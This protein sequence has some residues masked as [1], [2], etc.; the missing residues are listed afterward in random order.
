MSEKEI[1]IVDESPEAAKG[2]TQSDLESKTIKQLKEILH[3]LTLKV[4][5][6]KSELIERIINDKNNTLKRSLEDPENTGRSNKKQ[7]ISNDDPILKG[8]FHCGETEN[9]KKYHDLKVCL[10]CYQKLTE[11]RLTRQDARSFFK[12]TETEMKKLPCKKKSHPYFRSVMYL[13]SHGTVAKAAI[14]KYGSLKA[15]VESSK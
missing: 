1:T 2:F 6:T 9:L 8:C 5:G 11:R 13:Y 7:K 14:A 3:T 10:G 4:G 12:L 15:M